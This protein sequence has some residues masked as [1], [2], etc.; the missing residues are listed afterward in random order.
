MKDFESEIPCYLFAEKAVELAYNATCL[1]FSVEDNL[2][3]FLSML[4]SKIVLK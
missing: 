1:C 2:F 3:T 4:E